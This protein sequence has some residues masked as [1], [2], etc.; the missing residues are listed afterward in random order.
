M[1]EKQDNHDVSE[2]IIVPVFPESITDGTLSAIHKKVGDY[3][4]MGETVADIET[5]KVLFEVPSPV[6]GTIE[7][8]LEKEGAT[9]ISGQIIAK[10]IKQEAEHANSEKDVAENKIVSINNL[11]SPAAEKMMKENNITSSQVIGSGKDGRIMKEDVLSY[12]ESATEASANPE[13]T[14]VDN[15]EVNIVQQRFQKRVP[16][17]RL[18]SRIA[19]RLLEAQHNAA[20]L[21][22]FNEVNMQA[23]IKLRSKYGQKFEQTHGVRLGFMSFFI[24]AVVEALKKYPEIN[25]STEGNDIIYHGFVDMGVAI[26]SPRGLVVPI[27]R[28]VDTLSVSHIEKIIVDYSERAKT[29]KLSL[30]E[31]T[32]GTFSITNGGVFG[33]MLSTPILNPPQSGILGMHKIEKRVIV[34]NDEMVIRPMMYLAFS[35]D[36]RIID[37]R[38]AVQFLVSVKE[39]LEDPAMILLEI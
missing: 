9:V 37:G 18:R 20:I 11:Q 26:G 35:Y 8:V 22:T 3:V 29:G 34:E 17:S 38:E 23:I 39:E 32:G 2:N 19:E 28:D 5:D 25:A 4:N 30:D 12:I 31:I 15:P 33:S 7:A 36:H 10:V 27:I 13:I 6:S 21:T 14:K 24:K 16:M 1:N